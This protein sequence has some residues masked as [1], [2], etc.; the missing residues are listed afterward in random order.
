MAAGALTLPIAGLAPSV[1][2]ADG[3]F[4]QIPISIPA[5]MPDDGNKPVVLDGGVDVP[6]SGCPCPMIL[7][8]HGF[9]GNWTNSNDVATAFANHGYVVLRYSSRGFGKTTGEVDLVGDKETTDM[10]DAIKYVQ[11]NVG[12]IPQLDG[13][14]IKN[15]VGQYGGSYGGGHAWAAAMSTNPILHA[16]I[17]T[18]VPTA[19]WSDFYQALLPNDVMLTAYANG[20]YAT[21]FDPTATAVND[22][23]GVENDLAHQ[24]MPS[25]PDTSNATTQNYSQELHRWM[26]EA[27]SGVNI[28]D[29]KAGLDSRSVMHHLGDVHVPVFIVQGSN[30]G[31]F[32]ENQALAAYQAL[33]KRGIPARLYIGGIGHPPS[34]GA[35]DHPEALHVGAEMLAWFDHYLKGVDNGIDRM[36]PIEFSHA[37]YFDNKWDGTT[38]SAYA[39]PGGPASDLYLCTTGAAGGTLSATSC[40]AANPAVAVNLPGAGGGY[41]QEPVTASDIRDG[42]KQ[43]T[44]QPNEPICQQHDPDLSTYPSILKYD[45][46]PVATD[47]EWFGPPHLALQAGS[48]DV[49]PAGMEGEGA[50]FQLDPKFYDVAPD[51]S[52]TLITRGAYAEPL[53]G[54]APSPQTIPSHS[55]GYDAFGLSY[56]LPAGHHLR[57]TLSTSD[58]PYLRPTVNPFA[59]ALFAGSKL[60]LPT[61]ANSFPTPPIGQPGPSLPE[62]PW[63]VLLVAVAG[64]AYAG[65][66]VVRRRRLA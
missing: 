10:A 49:L 8:N 15:D 39:F 31:L 61:T 55:V 16:A 62:A 33:H 29:I 3:G 54:A 57:L 27:N 59:V 51:G 47:T 32:T 35:T 36:P 52:A 6:N 65:F 25:S 19:T 11:D 21:G 34:D 44:C 9:L 20:F 23:S 13:A 22:G 17:K 50:A 12:N 26:A 1:A 41:D 38:R 63:P 53:N 40:P 37:T 43:L 7:I 58:V 4:T 64:V 66:Y 2:H 28:P 56:V 5:S 24:R 45:A 48:V 30:D 60:S 46:D 42:I 14:V 18:T